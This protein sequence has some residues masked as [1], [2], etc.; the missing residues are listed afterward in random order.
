MTIISNCVINLVPDKG[1]AFKEAFSVLKPGGRLMVSDIVLLKTLPESIRESVDAYVGCISGALMKDEYLNAIKSAGFNDINVVDES[2]F[3]LDCM[4]NDPTGQAILED[5][6]V[7]ERQLKDVE[8][9]IAS[10]KVSG[11]KPSA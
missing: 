3:P 7:T 5:L 8:G 10:I 1:K 9:S 4:I 11:I 6:K 2:G